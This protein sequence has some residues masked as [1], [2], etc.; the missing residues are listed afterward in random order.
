MRGGEESKRGNSKRAMSRSRPPLATLMLRYTL[1]NVTNCDLLSPLLWQQSAFLPNWVQ[2][3]GDR[4]PLLCKM[5]RS[6][7]VARP[8]SSVVCKSNHCA[9][10]VMS[11]WNG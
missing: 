9:Y 2:T 3:T 10:A 11:M 4:S 8:G 7:Y 6:L 1:P 5:R